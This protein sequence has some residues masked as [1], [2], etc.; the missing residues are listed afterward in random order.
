MEDLGNIDHIT[1]F[2]QDVSIGWKNIEPLLAFT[3]QFMFFI[4]SG[5]LISSIFS[6]F[7]VSPFS[8]ESKTSHPFCN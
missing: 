2:L 5:T 4:A 8:S 1:P 7:E 6:L 3:K